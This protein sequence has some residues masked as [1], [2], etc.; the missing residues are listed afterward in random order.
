MKIQITESQYRTIIEQVNDPIQD[1]LDAIV[2]KYES[3]GMSC[4]IYY[5]KNTQSIE[6]SSIKIKDK[7]ARRQGLG[8][9][10]MG[11][12]SSLADKHGLV[13]VLTPD[14]SETPVSVLKRFYG[15]F[16]YKPNKGNKKD[17]RFRHSMIREPKK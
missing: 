5:N 12:I 7:S 11:E 17:F 6:I 1:E 2:T 14:G 16:D 9:S 4:W 8:T 13:S 15:G 3:L 10:L